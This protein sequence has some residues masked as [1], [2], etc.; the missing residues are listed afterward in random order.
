MKKKAILFLLLSSIS[1]S[2]NLDLDI[3][4]KDVSN[5][6]YEKNIYNIEQEK[7]EINKKF[8]KLDNYNGIKGSSETT[9]YREDQLYK[10]E[11]NLTFG[12]FYINGTKK[13]KEES[14]LVIGINKNIKDMLYSEN[15]KNLNNTLIDKKINT[16]NYFNNLEKKKLNLIDLYKEY[17]NIEFEIEAKRNGVKTLKSE[18]KILKESFNLGKSSKIDLTSA[19]INRENLEIELENLKRKKI[20]LQKRFFYDFKIKIEGNTL[21]EIPKKINN[22]EYFLNNIGKKDLNILNLEKDKIKENIKYLK[23]NDKYPDISIGFEHDFGSREEEVKENRI[24]L[25]ISKNLFYYDNNLENEKF[26]YKEK[27]LHITE[28]KNKNNSEILKIQE[29]YENFNKE[30]KVNKNKAILEKNKYEIKKLEYKLGKIKYLDLID[31]FNDF[32]T[33]TIDAEKS[34]NDLNAYIYK[35]IIRGDYNE[36][37]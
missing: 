31:S 15:D 9:Y 10:T 6:S 22:F 34:K 17:K 3:M 5:N 1:F 11:G 21:K 37:K 12:D 14:D 4:L 29:E 19:K 26:N 25:K 30:Y 13:E 8:Y 27:I 7:S 28:Q 18:E 24:Y 32:L 20:K 35:V 23:Y 36:N 16:L 33:Y 2:K